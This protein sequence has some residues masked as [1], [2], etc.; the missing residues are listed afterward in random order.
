MGK[1]EEGMERGGSG[2]GRRRGMEI[3]EERRIYATILGEDDIERK[4][5]AAG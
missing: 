2:N 3:R 1:G 4:G 5:T